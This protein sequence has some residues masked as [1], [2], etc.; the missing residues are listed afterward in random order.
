M[1]T[2]C[3]ILLNIKK[4]CIFPTQYISVFCMIL[5]INSDYLPKLRQPDGLC[6]GDVSCEVRTQLTNIGDTPVCGVC[7]TVLAENSDVFSH[8]YS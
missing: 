6:S 2:I 8:L 7:G 5:T 1:V 3:T 4:L